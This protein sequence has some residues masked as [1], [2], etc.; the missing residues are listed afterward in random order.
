MR[1]TREPARKLMD[2]VTAVKW[3]PLQQAVE[4][5]TRPHEKAFLVSV[6]QSCAPSQR[7]FRTGGC[8]QRRLAKVPHVSR[9]HQSLIPPHGIK[10]FLNY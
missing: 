2:D 5:L 1:A 6:G 3:L 4:A 8:R 9:N 10:G 7:T